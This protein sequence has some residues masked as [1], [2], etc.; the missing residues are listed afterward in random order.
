MKTPFKK[1]L[2]HL[3]L[4]TRDREYRKEWNESEGRIK[5]LK[6]KITQSDP[7]EEVTNRQKLIIVLVLIV[8][9]IAAYFNAISQYS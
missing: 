3:L 9:L 5:S 1:K 8:I 6:M 4:Y 7:V 2:M